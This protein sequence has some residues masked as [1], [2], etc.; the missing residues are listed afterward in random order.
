M[1]FEDLRREIEEIHV[2]FR[3]PQPTTEERLLELF[4]VFKISEESL[5]AQLRASKDPDD[6][7]RSDCIVEMQSIIMDKAISLPADSLAGVLYK[8][9][10][11]R[12][13]CAEIDARNPDLMRQE[14]IAFAAF[15]DLARLL[16]SEIVLKPNDRS[17]MLGA[18]PA[19]STALSESVS[20]VMAHFRSEDADSL[21][22]SQRKIAT[23]V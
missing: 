22:G 14:A 12:W 13:D 11:W 4:R 7:R 21:A 8:L 1:D 18:K 2:G 23:G 15:L 3:A 10:M 5:S 17:A 16:K 19:E 6:D 9:A 20:A